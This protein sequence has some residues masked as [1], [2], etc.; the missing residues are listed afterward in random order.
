VPE[1]S[2]RGAV[3]VAFERLGLPL[4]VAPISRI[5]EP[6]PAQHEIHLRSRALQREAR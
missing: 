2:A 4:P 1:G 5:V 6:R 3:L